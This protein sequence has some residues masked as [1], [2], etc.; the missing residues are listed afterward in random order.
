MVALLISVLIAFSPVAA[1]AGKGDVIRE[2]EKSFASMK[3]FTANFKQKAFNAG[4]GEVE[5][6]SGKVAIKKPLKMSWVYSKPEQVLIVDG[7]TIFFYVPADNQVMVEPLGKMLNSRSPLLFLAGDRRLSDLF[8]IELADEANKDNMD[9][10]HVLNLRPREESVSVTRIVVGVDGKDYTIRSLTL[11]DWAGNRTEI[12]FSD[13]E[14]N[15]MVS[16]EIFKFEKPKG[17]EQVE[18]PS[19]SFGAE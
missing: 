16:D 2:V 5:E 19:L 17:V 13:M 9:D 18:M 15:G 8:F 4:L 11:Y 10:G 6:S 3:S 7:R 14:I 12:E 1:F